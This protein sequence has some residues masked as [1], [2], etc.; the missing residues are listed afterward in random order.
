MQVEGIRGAWHGIPSWGNLIWSSS[1]G[2]CWGR[3]YVFVE[4]KAVTRA[5]S[6]AGYAKCGR[7]IGL[8]PRIT[9]P[10]H[11]I[12]ESGVRYGGL[13]KMDSLPWLR[14][15]PSWT[16]NC[17]RRRLPIISGR[18]RVLWTKSRGGIMVCYT[19]SRSRRVCSVLFCSCNP[20]LLVM[21]PRKGPE[22]GA[23]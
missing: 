16:F 2:S 6:V 18:V 5:S 8:A 22:S 21:V 12:L 20:G 9:L 13:G 11:V 14:L 7:Q 17:N 15:L 23:P 1:I 3:G 19:G 10:K 4:R